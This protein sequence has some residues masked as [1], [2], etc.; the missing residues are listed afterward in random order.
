M[1][2]DGW[3]TLGSPTSSRSSQRE[4]TG[5]RFGG[6]SGSRR[7]GTNAYVAEAGR[8]HR[9]GAHSRRTSATRRS[10]S[11]SAAGRRSRSTT[12]RT[13]RPAGIVVHL[14]DPSVR[15]YAR[16]EEPG[17][18]V[19]AIG[20]KP[21]EPYI[22]SAWEWYFEAEKFRPSMDTD[23]ALAFLSEGLERF[24]DHFGDGLLV[25]LLASAR[26]PRRRSARDAAPR[27]GARPACPRVGREGRGP[28]RPC[29]TGS[30]KSSR[31]PSLRRRPGRPEAGFA[32]R[33]ASNDSSVHAGRVGG[34]MATSEGGGSWGNHGFPHG[35]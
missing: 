33:E 22:P 2:G 13:T 24:P 19:L 30:S 23:A 17:T 34:T 9:R 31:R 26:R 25:R 28:R 15:R 29:A 1:K 16:A 27:R 6:R 32:G 3:Q 4:C 18:L 5:S 11:C 7:S 10:T 12:R 21:G 35:L 14:A 20:A 8:G